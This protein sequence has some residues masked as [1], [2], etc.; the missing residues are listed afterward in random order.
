M[1]SKRPVSAA[2]RAAC[3]ISNAPGTDE[4]LD[5][6]VAGARFLQ[7]RDGRIAQAAGDR[8]VEARDDDGERNGDAS[9]SGAGA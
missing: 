5:V 7:R 2:A 1:A 9:A 3:G 4:L 8:L 6:R